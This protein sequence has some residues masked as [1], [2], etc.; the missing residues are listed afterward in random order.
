[1]AEQRKS[2]GMVFQ[3]FNLFPHRTVLENVTEAPLLVKKEKKSLV[4]ER[5]KRCWPASGLN[6]AF[7]PGHAS[8]LVDS[9]SEWRSPAPWR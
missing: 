9:N 6:I 3:Q 1:M 4:V 7:T 5:A 8:F 2:I